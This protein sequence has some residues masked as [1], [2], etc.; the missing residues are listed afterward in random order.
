MMKMVYLVDFENVTSNGISGIQRLTKEDKV[1]IFYT[2]NASNLS[3][4]AHMNLLSSPAEI[5]YYNVASGGKN[6]LDFQ[7]A[8][9][10]GY[11][12]SKGDENDFC[13]ISNDQGFEFVRTFW[14][15]SGLASGISISSAPSIKRALLPAENPFTSKI[16]QGGSQ[17]IDIDEQ[18]AVEEAAV[19][20][21]KPEIEASVPQNEPEN[22]PAQKKKKSAS[23]AVPEPLKAVMKKAGVTNADQIKEV[24]EL[25][26]KSQNKQQ[27]YTGMTKIFG[28]EKGVEIYRV[29]RPEYTNL[30][31]LVK[32]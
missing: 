17:N 27:F 1:Y 12:I 22:V 19:Q 28:M 16:Q 3:F 6:A 2:V 31:K 30:T 24:L 23:N 4:A 14:E 5:I 29:I 32:Q 20:P 21:E 8:S 15:K 26:K 9:F 11:L 18:T 13:I 10:L 7:L 25:L